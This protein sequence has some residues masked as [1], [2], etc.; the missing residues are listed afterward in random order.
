MQILKSA[1]VTMPLMQSTTSVLQCAPTFA[2]ESKMARLSPRRPPNFAGVL[3]KKA[4]AMEVAVGRIGVTRVR[5][6]FAFLR[7]YFSC[8]FHIAGKLPASRG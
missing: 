6:F 2:R 1:P 7:L 5:Y 3:A 4:A 8:R